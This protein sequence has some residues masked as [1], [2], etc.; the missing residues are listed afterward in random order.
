M[1][2]NHIFSSKQKSTKKRVTDT[3]FVKK[4]NKGSIPV[5]AVQMWIISFKFV[6]ANKIVHQLGLGFVTENSAANKYSD[7][8]EFHPHGVRVCYTMLVDGASFFFSTKRY[9]TPSSW[10]PSKPTRPTTPRWCS[11]FK[12][13]PS[14]PSAASSS[15]KSYSRLSHIGLRFHTA[16]L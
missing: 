4:K 16:S 8:C 10:I 14:L 12:P 9:D 5:T 13:P 7:K 15:P 2:S 6:W 3:H 11:T 1:Q